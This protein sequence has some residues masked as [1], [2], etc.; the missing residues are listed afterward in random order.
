MQ[1]NI[2]VRDIFLNILYSQEIGLSNLAL[3]FKLHLQFGI[4][5]FMLWRK[6]EK[7]HVWSLY[8]LYNENWYWLL[9]FISIKSAACKCS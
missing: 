8:W 2:L 1:K 3:G 7:L 5:Q 9:K 6:G 4:F